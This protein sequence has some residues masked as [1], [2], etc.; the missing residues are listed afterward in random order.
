MSLNGKDKQVIFI[1]GIQG[2]GKTSLCARLKSD[3][4]CQVT[5]QRKSLIEV[6]RKYNLGWDDIGVRHDEYI[7]EAS[8]LITFNF[9]KNRSNQTL[10]IDC[11]YAIRAEKALR[12]NRKIINEA[13]IQDIDQRLIEKL[14]QNFRI[15]FALIDID[16][17]LALQ[18]FANRPAE[19]LG[20]DNTPEGLE[21]QRYF[22]NV[23]FNRI[24]L[25]CNI[26]DTE[27]LYLQNIDFEESVLA[28]NKF[29]LL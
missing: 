16:P 23:F 20:Y 26:K 7:E 8:D 1:G 9:L 13:Y 21:K 18:R 15:R 3:I 28:L 22:E 6:G 24:I 10:L 5:K 14:A 25:D 2:S 27:K 11:H 4:G 19:L 29:I 12:L 17:R